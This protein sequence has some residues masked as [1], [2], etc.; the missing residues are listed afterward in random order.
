MHSQKESGMFNL[1]MAH[2]FKAETETETQFFTDLQKDRIRQK[3]NGAKIKM[4]ASTRKRIASG[5]SD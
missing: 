4:M 3:A 5:A 2:Y 1:P